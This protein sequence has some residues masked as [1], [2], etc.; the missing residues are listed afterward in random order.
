[1]VMKVIRVLLDSELIIGLD[2][3]SKKQRRTRAELMSE[4][5]LSYLRQVEEEEMDKI[6]RRGYEEIP[7]KEEIGQA[8]VALTGSILIW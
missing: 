7:E 4:A 5:C 2:R 3:V 8:Q 1:M 6:Y